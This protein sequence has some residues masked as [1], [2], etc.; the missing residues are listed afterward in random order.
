MDNSATTITQEEA[1]ALEQAT[2][3]QAKCDLWHKSREQRLTASQFGLVIKRKKDV[4]TKFLTSLCSSQVIHSEAVSYGKKHESVAKEAYVSK[5]NNLH[6]HDCGLVVNPAYS[7]LAATPDG[8]VCDGG[9]TGILEIKCPYS[10]RNMTVAEAAHEIP[11]FFMATSGNSMKLKNT[12][13]YFYQVQGQLMVTG[14][15]F[16]D[17]VIYTSKDIH[18]ERILPDTEVWEAMLS[19]L[20]L[21]Y[22]QH[23]TPFLASTEK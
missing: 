2:V 10:A 1:E 12:H 18:I 6:V 7:F 16:C 4:N 8:K 23:I 19:K 14:A 15:P 20:T 11:T 17:F 3:H 13:Q 21:F 22:K 9:H 5:N